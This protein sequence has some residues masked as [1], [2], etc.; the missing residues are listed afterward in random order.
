MQVSGG[1]CKIARG[2]VIVM[3]GCTKRMPSESSSITEA[4]LSKQKHPKMSNPKISNAKMSNQVQL[5]T[6]H[7]DLLRMFNQKS[8][9]TTQCL[10]ALS[11]S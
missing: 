6:Y 8:K 4:C 7:V 9:A 2:S 5:E 10:I 3:E 1:C 11:S